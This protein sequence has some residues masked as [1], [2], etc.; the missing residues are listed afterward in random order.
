MPETVTKSDDTPKN[1]TEEMIAAQAGISVEQ[2][3]DML[4]SAE[5][6]RIRHT[7]QLGD[8]PRLPQ[9]A[10]KERIGPVDGNR[11]API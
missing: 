3:Q 2:L 5:Q 10:G 9:T 4:A 8:A 6:A 7:F 11:P 1:V